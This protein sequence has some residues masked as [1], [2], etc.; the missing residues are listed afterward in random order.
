MYDEDVNAE[1]YRD[2]YNQR[3]AEG[4]ALRIGC[5]TKPNADD[6]K[7]LREM[8]GNSLMDC[9]RILMENYHVTKME[10]VDVSDIASMLLVQHDAILYIL[11]RM[12][13]DRKFG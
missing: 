1:E 3:R 13:D 5:T 2:F 8:S 6:I 12:Q 7:L 9:N 10:T 4:K 11:K